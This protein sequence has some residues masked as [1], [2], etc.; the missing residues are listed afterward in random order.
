MK[1]ST[2]DDPSNPGK[3]RVRF[4]LPE[5]GEILFTQ[6]VGEV[7]SQNEFD[8]WVERYREAASKRPKGDPLVVD[9]VA[10]RSREAGYWS[11]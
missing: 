11:G 3:F 9:V 7:P 2:E 4:P 5:G 8:A 6:L 10:E 1:Y